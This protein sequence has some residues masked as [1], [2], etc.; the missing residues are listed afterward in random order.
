MSL[1]EWDPERRQ[2]AI[3]LPESGLRF[4]CPNRAELSLGRD[5]MWHVCRSCAALPE[6]SRFRV[7]AELSKGAGR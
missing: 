1:C 7:R 2:G 5:G 4:G 6:F 3:E